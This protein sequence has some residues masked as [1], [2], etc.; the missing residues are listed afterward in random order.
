[1]IVLE[2]TMLPA[3]EFF[4]V[5]IRCGV[6]DFALNHNTGDYKFLPVKSV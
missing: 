3:N 2:I 4:P 6:G 5:S 1:M